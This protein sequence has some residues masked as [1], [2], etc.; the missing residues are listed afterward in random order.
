MTVQS[1]NINTIRTDG[2]TNPRDHIN[3]DVVARYTEDMQAGAEFPPVIVFDDGTDQWLADGFHRV[4]VARAMDQGSIKAEVRQGT[5][6][7]AILFSASANSTH[8]YPRSNQDKRNAV[9]RLLNDDEWSQ[10]NDS[11]IAR[12]CKVSHTFVAKLRSEH[13]ATLQDS[14][15]VQRGGTTY[16]QDTKKIGGKKQDAPVVDDGEAYILNP[17]ISG[18]QDALAVGED[19]DVGDAVA[20]DLP[21]N[22]SDPSRLPHSWRINEVTSRPGGKGF[23]RLERWIEDCDVVYLR[24]D[25]A[26]NLVLL[27]WHIWRQLII[28]SLPKTRSKH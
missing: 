16:T 13:L 15:K 1:L 3:E 25:P 7:D 21:I 17:D 2:G 14:R 24:R 20:A 22:N 28:Q 23:V 27:P 11:E 26:P 18:K 8:G 6:R 12:Q 10:W 19:T 9:L 4:A 5:S